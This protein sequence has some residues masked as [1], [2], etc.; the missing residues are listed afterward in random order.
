MR[1]KIERA[2]SHEANSGRRL[3]AAILTLASCGHV[4]GLAHAEPAPLPAQHTVKAG[5]TCAAIAQQY[6]GDARLVELLH[7]ANPALQSVPPPHVLKEG[8]VLVI[9]PRDTSISSSSASPSSPDAQLTTVRN[10]VDV[11]APEPKQG[12]PNDPLFRG[13]RVSTQEASAADVTFRD[14]TQVKLGERT[15]VIILGDARSAA[16]KVET[17][18][19]LMTG[20]LRAFMTSP[21]RDSSIAVGTDAANVRVFR[22]QAQVSSD[23]QKTTRLAV[24]EGSS[25]I[26]AHGKT[27]EVVRGFGS[28][29]ELGKEPTVPHPLPIAPTWASIPANV[30]PFTGAS[31]Q[32]IIAEYDLTP[33]NP[34]IM[35]W[36]VQVARDESFRDIASDTLV[37]VAIKRLEIQTPSP[38]HYIAR[39]S[40][41]DDDHFE[42]PFSAPARFLVVGATS[43]SL[44]R[45][46][47]GPR[48]RV[49]IDPPTAYCMRVGNVP[50]TWVK[51]PFEV[52]ATEPIR[53]RCAPSPPEPTTLLHLDAILPR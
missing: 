42:G 48:R 47:A 39:V 26:D 19:T 5:D 49:E 13:N 4:P 22:G 33:A 52:G 15:L 17:Q 31:T 53:L 23:A 45:G 11:A 37:P 51:G 28:K 36:H 24:Y 43:T 35:Q 44:P 38:G 10:R 29:A 34:R 46:S 27:R 2:R 40:A 20:N 7:R 41:L 14:E 18:M 25:M 1:R 50:L 9:P 21:R 12:K 16:A 32:P 8:T 3:F 30:L 6:Y